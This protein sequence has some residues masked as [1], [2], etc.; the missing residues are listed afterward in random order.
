[1]PHVI[2]SKHHYVRFFLSRIKNL[3]EVGDKLIKVELTNGKNVHYYFGI[4][5][6]L[7]ELGET[8]FELLKEE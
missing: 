6:V 7:V 5:H 8:P 3:F 2:I 4:E 1:M